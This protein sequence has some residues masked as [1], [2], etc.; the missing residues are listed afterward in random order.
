MF[1][2][3]KVEGIVRKVRGRVEVGRLI[4]SPFRR[5]EKE[6]KQKNH[7]WMGVYRGSR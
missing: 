3:Y 7:R 1:I 4:K 2:F 6:R 5:R